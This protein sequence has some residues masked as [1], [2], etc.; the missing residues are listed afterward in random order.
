M[1]WIVNANSVPLNENPGTL[2]NVN[3][4]M[5]DWFVPI[6]FGVITKTILD[7]QVVETVV[8][9]SFHGVWQP[10]TGRQIMMKPEGQRAW[11]WFMLHSDIQIDLKIDDIIV[12]LGKQFR[13]MNNK[14]YSLYGYRYYELVEDWTGTVPTP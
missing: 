10:L 12:Y 5:Q 7:F 3:S 1:S 2:P 13:V 8:D 6:T 11:N 14:D 4:V 9:M